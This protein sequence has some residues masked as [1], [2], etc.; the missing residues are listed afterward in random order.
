MKTV[1]FSI[2]LMKYPSVAENIITLKLL[3]KYSP[4]DNDLILK[5][6]VTNI[7][8]IAEPSA[9]NLTIGKLL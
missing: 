9:L 2:L 6:S 4:K 8:S 3:C 7:C 1:F 5:S